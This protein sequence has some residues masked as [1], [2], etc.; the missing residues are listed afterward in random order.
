MSEDEGLNLVERLKYWSTKYGS[1]PLYLDAA[2]EI[3]RLQDIIRSCVHGSEVVD[4]G[5]ESICLHRPNKHCMTD[6]NPSQT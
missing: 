1:Y 5:G 3:E 4:I 6:A 2:Y